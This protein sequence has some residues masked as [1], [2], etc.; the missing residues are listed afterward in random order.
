MANLTL[1]CGL[2][3][4]GK[5]TYSQKYENV[6]HL[7]SSGAYLG[8]EK[9]VNHKYGDIIVEGVYAKRGQRERLIAACN[10]D[11]FKCIWLN[12]PDKIRHSRKGWDKYCDYPFDPPTFDEGWDEIIIIRGDKE[13]HFLSPQKI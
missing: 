5:T 8:V 6:I 1:I 3:R 10:A 2:P 11:N 12:T 4:A 7:D 13:E 9:R